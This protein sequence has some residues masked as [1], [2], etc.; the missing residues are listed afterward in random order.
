[1]KGRTEKIEWVKEIG[2][3]EGQYFRQNLVVAFSS[4]MFLIQSF[5]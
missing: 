3:M 4:N 1:M 2:F 5:Y